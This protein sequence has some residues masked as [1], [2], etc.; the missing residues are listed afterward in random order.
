MAEQMERKAITEYMCK[1]ETNVILPAY[2]NDEL[3]VQRRWVPFGTGWL[4]GTPFG[5]LVTT[6]FKYDGVL[7]LDYHGL[8]KKS[9]GFMKKAADVSAFIQGLDTDV[10]TTANLQPA[11]VRKYAPELEP[12]LY[13][14]KKTI[15][16]LRLGET[17]E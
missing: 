9:T 17:E 6:R 13:T 3:T 4:D 1:V 15:V 14:F 11:I 2:E 16:N 10:I 12:E 8:L 5:R 7:V